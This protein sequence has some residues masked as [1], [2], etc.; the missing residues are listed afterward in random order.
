MKSM[1]CFRLLAMALCMLAILPAFAQ[2]NFRVSGT[3]T[4]NKGEPVA[5]ATVSVAGTNVGTSTNETGRFEVEAAKGGRLEISS[6]GYQALV[7]TVQDGRT[8]SIVLET[9]NANL[10]EVVVMG[11]T[12]RRAKSVTGVA[13][14]VNEKKLKDVPA[15]SVDRMLQG[16]VAGVFVGNSSGD[17][18]SDPEI[19]IRGIGSLTAG[20]QPLYVVDGV[21]GGLPNPSDVETVTVLKDAAATTLYGARAANGVIV[22]TTKRGRS[23]PARFSVRSTVGSGRLNLGN[24]ELMQSAE[25]YELQRN[26]YRDTYT[27]NEFDAYLETVLPKGML[28]SNTD[29]IRQSFGT[30]STR[31]IDLSVSGGSD[32]S[33][34]YLGGNYYQE[35]GILKGTGL[36]RGSF[37][38]NT[39]NKLTQKLTLNFNTSAR[40]RKSYDHSSGSNYQAYVNVPWDHPYNGAGTPRDP[41]LDTWYGRDASNFVFNQQY[42][43]YFNNVL[44]GEGLIKGEYV[45]NNNWSFA[46]T[47]RITGNFARSETI[48]DKRTAAGADFNGQLNNFSDFSYSYITSNLL[49]YK[50][51][52]ATDHEVDG[53]LGYEYQD[54]YYESSSATGR[55]IA[56]DIT[57]LN[58][59]STAAAVG[60][61]KTGSSFASVLFQGN[62][63]FKRKYYLTTSFRRD[64]SSRF[65]ANKKYGN[66]FSIGGSWIISDEAFFTPD[67]ISNLKLRASFGTTGNAN[68]GDYPAYG[69]YNVTGSYNG[70]PAAFPSVVDNPDLSWEKAYTTNV[71]VDLS[72]FKNRVELTIDVY[73][74]DN[75][76]LL[77]S[78]PLPGT[79]G[80]GSITRN[81]G[82]VNNKG[83]EVALS[84]VNVKSKVFEWSTDFNISLNKN[85]ITSLYGNVKEINDPAGRFRFVVGEDMRTFYLRR[86]AGVD[87]Q[88]G[89]PLWEVA[90]AE[91]GYGTTNVYNNATLQ[92]VGSATPG[93]IGSFRNY[94][95]YKGLDLTAFFTFVQGNLVYNTNRELFDNDGAY[96]RYNMMRLQDSWYRWEKAGDA[97][98]HPRY[99]VGGNKNAHRP[100]SRFLED[101]SYIRLRSLTLGYNLPKA[102]LNKV[103]IND[104]RFSIS[105][106][107]LF[108]LTDFS[109]I[110][111]EAGDRGE[112]GTKYPYASKV[113]FGLQLNF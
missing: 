22:I 30:A 112:I 103:K 35:D 21:I 50:Q 12:T 88:S 14:T 64:G 67:Y 108:T 20:N 66:F 42:N 19:R 37:R 38:L 97:A 98:T 87:P 93:F 47:N 91:G 79:T 9:T 10:D 80:Y 58:A 61:F 94:I 99:V 33:R 28:D 102:W 62:Y 4:N 3:V 84:A 85:K 54:N 51:E 32:K 15:S 11:Y 71:G 8:L 25:Y 82:T 46:S 89:D 52:I 49:K 78:V 107:N 34:Y 13:A 111:P 57:I 90:K 31:D 68:I 81:I 86:W 29:W 41:R 70:I 77:F 36:K 75:K 106:E 39:E 1:N 23:G 59:T 27:G 76:D 53:L 6:V 92:M 96:N 72:L 56:S 113:L 43:R 63:N 16:K 2:N 110:D 5:G 18:N 48:T 24:F 83:L 104:L 95:A 40:Y 26:Y 101:G 105:G 69:R 45:F 73:N 7:V 100:S 44:N 74:R 65:G 55:G 17:P 60:G 109:G